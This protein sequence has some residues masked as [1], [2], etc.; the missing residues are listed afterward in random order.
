LPTV[1]VENAA[2]KIISI[3]S[4]LFFSINLSTAQ[5]YWQQAVDYK[6]A[7]DFDVNSNQ[8][9]GSQSLLYTNNSPDTLFRVFYHLY[10]NAF[11]PGSMMDVRSR[12]IT[13][14]GKKI[15][16]RIYDLNE[17]E[18]G[19][20]K[21]I[22]LKQGGKKLNYTIE[23]TVLEVALAKPIPPKE[24]AKFE[25]KFESQVP[26]Q[27]R[28]SGRDNKE[29]IR[30][31]MS[32]W[33]PK[34]AEYD[35]SGWHAH[36]YI[37][38][39][40]YSPWGNYEVTINIDESYMI[41]ATGI[42]QNPDEIGY[43][44]DAPNSDG[45]KSK[46]GRLNWKFKA[47]NV[48][49][50]VWA[51]DTNYVH[52]IVVV[53]GQPD[54][55]YFYQNEEKVVE[56]WKELQTTMTKAIPFMNKHFGRYP[57]SKYAIIQGGDGGMEYP[58]A[59]LI[60]G[61][62]SLKGLVSVSIHEMMHS[63]YQMILATNESYFAWMDEGFTSYA[64]GLTKDFVYN[65][66]Q[67]SNPLSYRY[68]TYFS[69][70]KSGLEEPMSTHADHYI[71]N[72]AYG[73]AAYSKGAISLSQLEYIVG[74]KVLRKGLLRYFDEWK[75]KHPD[76]NDFIRVMEKE[77]EMELNWYYEYWVNTTNTIDYGIKSVVSKNQKTALLLEKIGEMPMPLD[78]VVKLNSGEIKTYN[79]PLRIM[80]GEKSL[81]QHAI[82][83]SDWPWVNPYYTLSL[84]F[85]TDDIE[86][87]EI[88]PSQRMAD[89]DRENN[90]YPFS[91]KL[92]LVGNPK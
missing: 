60:V 76:L 77:S 88:D 81:T 13:D 34:I 73:T 58:M 48:H 2:M 82:L 43:G 1:N 56:N 61:T 51:A 10:F 17:N 7:I 59:T 20:H 49:D 89:V 37:A 63:W 14:P 67:S 72:A 25:M 27:I 33:F 84:P 19:Y 64:Q 3:L 71:T 55:H 50:F 8:F 90:V 66:S 32:Q 42:L 40:F 54:M 62:I 86:S 79:I 78:V 52:D 38:R 28:R 83:M 15:G 6:M 31:S 70:V 26:L 4:I 30:Y 69:I 44:Y 11:Q 45:K 21:I 68:N 74:K 46:N 24:T 85:S 36:P 87:I 29:G 53:T 39:E 16:G 35:K 5:N 75:F 57:Y 18:I 80:R 47:E 9:T 65:D 92:E 41:G 23:G 12:T 91:R 22:S